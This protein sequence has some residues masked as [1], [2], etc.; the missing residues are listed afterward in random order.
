MTSSMAPLRKAFVQAA[1]PIA[2]IGAV[3]GFIGDIIQPL[4][5]FAV[6]IAGLSLVIAV[7]A[8]IWVTI[9]RRRAG[10]VIWDTLAAGLFVL[11]VGSFVVFS[12]WS[13]IFAV[14]PERGYLAENVEPIG[15]IQ[16]QL[17]GLQKDVTDI[18]QTTEV[19][20]TRVAE[21]GNVQSAQATRQAEGVSVQQA[22]ATAQAKGFADLQSQ[23]AS[24]QKG[25]IVENPT[26]PQGRLRAR[27]RP[28]SARAC[29]RSCS[30][31]P[32]SPR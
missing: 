25:S 12:A 28:G 3:G 30:N 7:V 15:Q 17:L 8:L 21:Q 31:S 10:V 6:W 23:F 5:N 32:G 26:T 29:R 4:G 24:L 16:A 13:I 22:A 2:V 18:K 20:A 11:A 1:R 14:G 19:T 27:V 9:L